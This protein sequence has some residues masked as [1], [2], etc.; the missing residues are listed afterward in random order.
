[1][2]KSNRKRIIRILTISL[3]LC[4]FVGISVYKVWIQDNGMSVEVNDK[5]IEPHNYV[6]AGQSG[7]SYW[8]SS[9]L[10]LPCVAAKSEESVN[11]IYQND[12][13]V[14]IT[15]IKYDVLDENSALGANESRGEPENLVLERHE[16]GMSFT[17]PEFNTD[18][19]LVRCC[20]KWKF[21]FFEK[22]VEYIFSLKNE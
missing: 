14:K 21:L 8:D 10:S 16:D 20:C 13:P 6:L 4:L 9:V 11:L 19:Q 3:L 17:V 18:Y 15:V 22:D 2:E 12:F 1:M 5:K 7:G